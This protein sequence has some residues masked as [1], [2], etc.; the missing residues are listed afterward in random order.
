[1]YVP[2]QGIRGHHQLMTAGDLE[3]C[4]IITDT[5]N[6][7]LTRCGPDTKIPLNEI[8]FVQW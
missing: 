3:Y 2:D 6:H 1:M 8:E 5:G 4:R 7:S